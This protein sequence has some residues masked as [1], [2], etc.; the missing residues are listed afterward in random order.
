MS[1]V[2]MRCPRHDGPLGGPQCTPPCESLAKSA[3]LAERSKPVRGEDER[4]S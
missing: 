4:G 1:D 2:D 3:W